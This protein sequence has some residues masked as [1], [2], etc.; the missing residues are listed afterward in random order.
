MWC[1]ATPQIGTSPR[2]RG[3]RGKQGY[4]LLRK[5]NIPAHAGKTL[6]VTLKSSIMPEHPRACGENSYKGSRWYNDRGTSPRMRG[7]HHILA[8]PGFCRR[9][10]P[11]H[12][13]KTRYHR[14]N[15]RLDPEHP[16]ACGENAHP[17]KCRCD[18]GGTSPRM[19]GK[20]PQPQQSRAR[21]RNIPA[22]AG[23][24]PESPPPPRAPE[25]P[26]ACGENGP[27]SYPRGVK[28][29]TSP[30]MRGKPLESKRVYSPRRNIPAHAGKTRVIV[31]YID[32]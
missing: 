7:K 23:K 16:R 19:R 28:R 4:Y 21:R 26:R 8:A 24:T 31:V 25:H 9:N 22:H 14:P 6:G 1:T 3:K 27:L 18:R 29:G 10:I 15:R 12:A 2:M 32:D 5:R 20:L 13:G 30:R 17:T 11:A